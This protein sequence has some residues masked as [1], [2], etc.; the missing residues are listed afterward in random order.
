MK[1]YFLLTLIVLFFACS[2]E[3]LFDQQAN[4]QLWLKHKGAEMPVV[5]EGNTQ[6]KIFLLFIH[7]GPG[8]TAQVFNEYLSP[9]SDALEKNHAMVYWDQRNSGLSRGEWDASKVTLEQHIEDL[10]QVVELLKF[11]FGEDITIFLIAHSWG[12]YLSQAYLLQAELQNKI[13]G[14]IN[15]NG[16]FH[17]NQNNKDAIKRI[18]EIAGEELLNENSDITE[19]WNRILNTALSELDKNIPQYDSNL[20]SP[21]F[22][23]IRE[24]EKLITDH[25][26][27][28][29]NTGSNYSATFQNNLHPFITSVNN[30][31]LN[32][33]IPQMYTFDLFVEN[34]LELIELPALFISG[35][36][37][38]RTPY[39]QAEYTM[40]NISTPLIDKELIMCEFSDHSSPAN[41]PL[42]I[43][44]SIE[45]FVEKYK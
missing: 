18:I 41:E 4:V 36:Y 14:W 5:V 39:F 16:L 13:R 33:L 26:F 19:E 32:L 28:E 8:G 22:S 24:T 3:N 17:R 20:E 34:N 7:G 37:D 25:S 29:Y 27:L 15:I 11:K 9:F 10:D 31:T 12:V 21:V 23:L 2:K 45:S 42:K 38:V 40:N 30:R 44:L 6:S 35:K 43:A 1:N